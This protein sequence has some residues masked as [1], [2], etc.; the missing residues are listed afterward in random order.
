MHKVFLDKVYD[1]THVPMLLVEEETVF[2]FPTEDERELYSCYRMIKEKYIKDKKY[3]LTC[4]DDQIYYGI[5]NMNQ[6]SILIGPVTLNTLTSKHL[7]TF[8]HDLGITKEFHIKKESLTNISKIMSLVIYE[9]TGENVAYQDINNISFEGSSEWYAENDSEVYE[10]EYSENEKSHNSIEIEKTICK[11]VRE[12]DIEAY[13]EFIQQDRFDVERNGGDVAQNSTKKMEYYVVTLIILV[14]RAA[15]EGGLH[16]EVSLTL[17]DVYLRKLERCQ[18]IND[19]QLLGLKVVYEFITK[20]NEAIQE[21]SGY[22][23]IEQCKDYIAKNLRLNFKVSD[24]ADAIGM[25]RC[26]LSRK[27]HES[28]GM[29]IQQYIS[30][31]RCIHAANLLKF[32]DYPISIISEYFC[33]SSQSHF[34]RQ[35]KEFFEMTPNEY[36]NKNKHIMSPYR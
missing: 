29:T 14:S 15:I 27:F 19:I 28:E 2:A 16:P 3:C 9:F 10:L 6:F 13:K 32:S 20:V 30:H 4:F 11:M 25:N 36:R 24:I 33:F 7:K 12:G 23:Y 5:I 26:Y 31:E 1:Y 17:S 8:K 35:F 22:I 18:D 21:R 34:G